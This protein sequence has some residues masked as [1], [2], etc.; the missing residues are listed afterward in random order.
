M[1]AKGGS[2]AS[3][4]E[5]VHRD[6]FVFDFCPYGAP[7]PHTTRTS[8]AVG[9]AASSGFLPDALGRLW[10]E[11][12]GELEA[13]GAER[14]RARTLWEVSG[15][16]GL[17]VTLGAMELRL[18]DWDATLRDAARWWRRATGSRD[19]SV[20]TTPAALLDAKYRGQVGVMLGLQDT[21]QIG[22]DLTRLETLYGLGVR[23]IQLTYNRRNLVGDG[24]TEPQQSG[25]SRFGLELI[26]EL[27]RL[28][29]VIDVSHSGTA[30]TTEAIEASRTPVAITHT[31]CGSLF[32][33][34]RA[35]SD[36]Q[37]A[38]LAERDGY[39]GI[40]AVPYFLQANNPDIGT[41]AA[42]IEHAAEIVGVERVGVATDWGFWSLDF[43]AE[44]RA[45]AQAAFRSS[46]FREED[47][48][49]LGIALDGL[50]QWTD[51]PRI[52]EKLLERGFTDEQVRG[53]LGKNWLDFLERVQAGK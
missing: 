5:T 27:N 39:V 3:R 52:T 50:E 12:L 43:P 33:H 45:R 14:E 30:T 22:S 32:D 23:V 9:E 49:E 44:F 24:C 15:V 34:P 7:V 42:H 48:V 25:L 19:V 11:H 6:S 21:L 47:G 17:Q 29:I 2:D 41:M 53:I 20:C 1:R 46:G 10:D 18:H 38:L 31:A 37:L 4:A 13:D 8:S 26:G 40:V 51:W 36:D 35:K 28:G 16:N